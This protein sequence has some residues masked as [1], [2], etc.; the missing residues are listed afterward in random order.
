[1]F[2]SPTILPFI[3]DT[4]IAETIFRR[5]WT[6]ASGWT[7]RGNTSNNHFSII[8]RWLITLDHI[9]QGH[10]WEEQIFVHIV[11]EQ[12]E[13]L[14]VTFSI[15]SVKYYIKSRFLCTFH[16]HTSDL[17]L[18]CRDHSRQTMNNRKVN[19][20]SNLPFHRK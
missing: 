10:H 5:T 13:I 14:V 9:S 15:L 2:Y 6:P 3:I 19:T 4:V 12:E 7:T 18:P 1:M 11:L 8:F 20:T 17:K 16:L